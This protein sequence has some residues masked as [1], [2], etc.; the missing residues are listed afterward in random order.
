MVMIQVRE[1]PGE[2]RFLKN[3]RIAQGTTS[4]LTSM[5]LCQ[6][7]LQHMFSQTSWI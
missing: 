4:L 6:R 7:Y 5:M 1:E 2:D 3:H